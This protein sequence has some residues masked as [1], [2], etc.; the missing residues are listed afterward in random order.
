MSNG[1]ET[2]NKKAVA[3]KPERDLEYRGLRANVPK[4]NIVRIEILDGNARERY[5]GK[6]QTTLDRSVKQQV[7]Q[8]FSSPSDSLFYGFLKNSGKQSVGINAKWMDTGGTGGILGD[9]KG[10]IGEASSGS[11]AG[12]LVSSIADKAISAGEKLDSAAKALGG[13]DSK[14][15]GSSSLKR[16]EGIDMGDMSVDCGWYLP[17]QLTLA[18]SSLRI[19]AR[20][21]YPKQVDDRAFQQFV[22]DGVLGTINATAKALEENPGVATAA[23]I[24]AVAGTVANPV[25]AIA[26]VATG[27][28]AT[29]TAYA[30]APAGVNS[31]HEN[32]SSVETGIF[33]VGAGAANIATTI[34]SLVGRNL[35]LDPLP[36][37]VSIGHY[38]D[39]EP[40]VITS[41]DVTFSR[42]QW[43]APNGRHLPIFCDV[44]I[45]FSAWLNP[46]PKLE[47]MQLLGTEMFGLD[48]HQKDAIAQMDARHK[49]NLADEKARVEAEASKK[50]NPTPDS[51]NANSNNYSSGDSAAKAAFSGAPRVR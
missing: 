37:R 14:L 15:T 21:I 20:M 48:P 2:N 30:A 34:N 3:D 40:M 6:I 44:T 51:T 45:K 22:G 39:V 28:V 8:K 9:I 29:A 5:L 23:G 7:Y 43:V 11:T 17:E 25:A 35:T 42:E 50:V 19:L 4:P 32:L 41:I 47:F 33:K 46:A 27:A 31:T 16:L 36:V 38:I 13:F 10:V 26:T 49:K 18:S 1:S 12:G 24:A